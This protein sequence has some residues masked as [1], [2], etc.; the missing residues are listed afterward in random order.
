M[1]TSKKSLGQNFLIDKNICRKIVNLIEVKNK[2]ILEIGPGKGAL[3]DVII[4]LNPKKLILIEKDNEIYKKLLLKYKKIKSIILIN[5]DFLDFNLSSIY[6]DNIISNLP[7]NITTK[8]LIKLLTKNNNTN[9]LVLMV[10]KEV[11]YKIKNKKN[12]KLKFLIE[13]LCDFK[14]NFN[15]P[16][17]IFHPKPK[18]ESSII[19]LKISKNKI[20][21]IK[22]V[23][24]ANKIFI[25]KRKKIKSLK[26]KYTKPVINNK[27]TD[28]RAED[29]SNLELLELFNKF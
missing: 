19:T 9:M 5:E 15:L 4:N 23:N 2:S 29:L 14:I 8:A 27:L 24:F 12:N 13:T 17:H 3:T 1:R 6:I 25:H 11:A 16:N 10:Q 18:V 7:Y 28:F 20:D 26:L 22:L 21:K